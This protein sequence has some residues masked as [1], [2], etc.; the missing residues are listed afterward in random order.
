MND[1]SSI[2]IWQVDAFTDTP[3]RGNAAAVCVL[4][5][6]P[7][8]RWLQAVA[9]EL[10][11]SE[12][13]F[14]VPTDHPDRFHLRWFTPTV[15]VDLCGHATLA[16]THTLVEQG[17]A[18]RDQPIEFLTRSGTLE[19]ERR[20]SG[21]TLNFPA[22]P[23]T[24][25]ASAA[26]RD[27][28][29]AALGMDSGTV[30]RSKQDLVVVVEDPAHVTEIVPDYR[31]LAGIDTRGVIVTC[32]SPRPGIDFISRFFAP[33]FG[34]DEDPVTGS[35]HCSLA[36]YWADRIGRRSLTGYQ[37]SR[38]GGT[39]GCKVTGDRVLLSGQAVTVLEGR[40]HVTPE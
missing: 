34:I 21:I 19:C 14:V 36:P 31:R 35:A 12:T 24:G 17:R 1:D 30:L 26:D 11:L 20:E 7:S 15:E 4:D 8:D 38:R 37:A 9:S 10:Q 6:F 18:R 25:Q 13:A 5:V 16:A 29:I 23:V 33:R 3:F 40:L 39:V 22:A 32:Q 28:V 27:E 2:A